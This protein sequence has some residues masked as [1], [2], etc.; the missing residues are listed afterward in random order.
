M[1]E[2]GRLDGSLLDK[3]H[4]DCESYIEP[5]S[6]RQGPALGTLPRSY[7][8][9]WASEARSF[10]DAHA[11][12]TMKAVECLP[13]AQE[14]IDSAMV[15]LLSHDQLRELGLERVCGTSRVG[16]VLLGGEVVVSAMYRN[17]TDEGGGIV[18]QLGD[19]MKLQ[20]RAKTHLQQLQEVIELPKPGQEQKSPPESRKDSIVSIPPVFHGSI[21]HVVAVGSHE[22]L[23]AC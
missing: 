6:R 4:L 10:R 3:P 7:A 21:A 17:D 12:C 19:R 15:L 22:P 1:L 23:L 14:G 8:A 11:S 2:E 16:R 5:Q 13:C 9:S 20:L 18:R